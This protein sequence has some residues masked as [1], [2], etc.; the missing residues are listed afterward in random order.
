MSLTH[1]SRVV[2]RAA[3]LTFLLAMLGSTGIGAAHA[4]ADEQATPSIAVTLTS[5]VESLGAGDE[6]TYSAEITNR[7][8]AL[9]VRVVLTPPEFVTVGSLAG[10]EVEDNE[11]T[12]SLTLAAAEATAI[13]IPVTVGD[14][15]VGERRAT[16]LLS[17]YL[18]DSTR[19]LVRTASA[20]LIDGVD[21]EQTVA[22]SWPTVLFWGGTGLTVVLAMVAIALILLLRRRRAEV[23]V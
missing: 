12:W 15:P 8:E 10:A 23:Q 20:D 13:E 11:V 9:Q 17:V 4:A 1:L 3:V 7:G 18:G 14:I 2:S 19:P 16:A 21:D 6:L 5:G 22:S